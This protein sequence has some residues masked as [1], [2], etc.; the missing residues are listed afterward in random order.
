MWYL[1]VLNITHTV[2][3][4]WISELKYIQQNFVKYVKVD[5]YFRFENS[6]A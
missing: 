1:E 2:G 3:I 6:H 5:R 4:N